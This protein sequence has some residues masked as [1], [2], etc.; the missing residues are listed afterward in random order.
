MRKIITLLLLY[1]NGLINVLLLLERLINDNAFYISRALAWN[2]S[3]ASLKATMLTGPIVRALAADGSL[4]PSMASHIMVAVLQ[5]LQ[6][7]GQ[8]EANQGSL[9]TLGAQVYECLRPK[10]PNIIEVMQQIPGVNPTD[11]QRF[12][13]KMAVI[14]TKGNKVE[15]GKKDLFKKITNQVTT[16]K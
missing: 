8:H 11:L 9:I 2:D 6:L 5:G 4:T 1:I 12:D 15:K 16:S 3:N 10:F 7:H 14:S 13:E